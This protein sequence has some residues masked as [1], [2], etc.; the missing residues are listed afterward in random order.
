MVPI[1]GQGTESSARRGQ[2]GQQRR[3]RQPPHNFLAG[4]LFRQK[5]A[6]ITR[7]AIRSMLSLRESAEARSVAL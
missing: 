5:T 2:F 3:K 4:S 7:S 1:G 6:Y